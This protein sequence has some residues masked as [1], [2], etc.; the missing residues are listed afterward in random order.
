MT[1]QGQFLS[2]FNRC[3]GCL[4]HFDNISKELNNLTQLV[5]VG[6]RNQISEVSFHVT[7][8]ISGSEFLCIVWDLV[9]FLNLWIGVF[10]DLWKNFRY[11]VLRYSFYISTELELWLYVCQL[12]L[13][14]LHVFQS[15]LHLQVFLCYILLY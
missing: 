6:R 4:T 15:I 7:W 14:V 2:Y 10:P 12:P 8:Q 9:D 1:Q 13:S 11:Y 5:T 3:L